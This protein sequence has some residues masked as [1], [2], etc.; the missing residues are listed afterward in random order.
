MLSRPINGQL[1]R[2]GAFLVLVG[3]LVVFALQ[4]R[5]L[6]T[7]PV[8]D[9]VRWGGDETWL[10]REFG[11]QASHGVMSYPE[12]FG[13]G[14]RTDGVLAGSMWVDALIY[15]ATGNLF[16]PAHDYVSVGR[17]VT[18][19]LALLLI[20]SIYFILRKLRVSPLLASASVL[21][22]VACQGFVWAAH[23]ARYDLLTGLALI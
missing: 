18:A 17:T 23:S 6:Y 12:S 20:A 4:L 10:M 15:G 8:Y 13:G 2:Y 1:S 14:Q 9:S 22:V 16:F 7:V 11:D 5:T 3:A 21:L 19:L